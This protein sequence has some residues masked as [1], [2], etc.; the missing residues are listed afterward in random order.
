MCRWVLSI[1]V[2]TLI[3]PDLAGKIDYY[4]K[5][6]AGDNETDDDDGHG[7]HICGIIAATANNGT[8]VAGVAPNSHLLVADVFSWY[9]INGKNT[10]G[11]LTSEI[12]EGLNA[13][14]SHG[15]D[16]INMSLGN[17]VYDWSYE[18][19]INSAVASGVVV[20]TAAGNDNTAAAHYPSDFNASIAVISNQSKQYPKRFFEL[21]IRQRYSGTGRQCQRQ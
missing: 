18:A 7:T 2:W 21:W 4:Y 5:A 8:G 6:V 9:Y 15:A 13:V 12:V 14:V 20:V 1:P 16:V 11:A 17:Y 10:F 19:A 3:T